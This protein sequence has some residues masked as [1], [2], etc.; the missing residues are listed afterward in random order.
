MRILAFTLLM[1]GTH[2]SGAEEASRL[3]VLLER[4]KP[5]LNGVDA[6]VPTDVPT[7]DGAPLRLDAA[8]SVALALKH[9][10]QIQINDE[11][12]AQAEAR[13][14]QARAARMPQVNSQLG[15]SYIDGLEGIGTGSKLVED[16]IGIGDIQP[17]KTIGVGTVSVEQVLYAGGQIKAAI[18]ASRF[19]A[20][21]ETWQREVTRAQVALE[22]IQAFEDAIMTQALVEVARDSVATFERHRDD[23]QHAV[24][25]G[26]ASRIV[27]LRADTELQARRADAVSAETAHSIAL[28]NLKR[29]TGVADEQPVTLA[30]DAAWDT[31][32]TPLEALIAQALE[33]RAELRA[34]DQGIA[35]AEANVDA[36]RGEYRPRAAASLQWQ[37]SAG[38]GALQPDGFSAK[39]GLEWQIFAG[40]KRKH[41]V[42]EAESQVRSLEKQ[43]DDVRRLIELD[44]RQAHLRVRD[45]IEKLRR[46]KATLALAEEGLRLAQ[47][48]FREGV[49]TQ[50]EVLDA[51]LARS[52]AQTKIVQALRDYAVAVAGQQKATGTLVVPEVSDTP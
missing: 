8:T 28:L 50:T 17:D 47:V 51:S 37:Q 2:M 36:K 26:F 44:L 41:A 48:R 11:D 1:L 27:L 52:Q 40:G 39:A 46:D 23:A 10:A 18:Q 13:T 19:L 6:V 24:D 29:L 9:S 4:A 49:G 32:S 20:E 33:K 3:D 5:V 14:G 21:S 42:A 7:T 43:R 25:V 12:I 15:I 22:T 35:A 45:A 38:S 34:L 31:D 16:L 30:G